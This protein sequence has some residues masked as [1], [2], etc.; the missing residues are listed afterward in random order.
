MTEQKQDTSRPW[1]QKG[2]SGAATRRSGMLSC[3]LGSRLQLHVDFLVEK[4]NTSYY[5]TRIPSTVI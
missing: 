4:R 1:S 5:I 2:H 3:L